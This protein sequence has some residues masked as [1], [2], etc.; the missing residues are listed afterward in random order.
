[1]FFKK[2]F[3]LLSLLLM[4]Y[5]A[6]GRKVQTLVDKRYGPGSYHEGVEAKG[7]EPGLYFTV[8]RLAVV[9]PSGKCLFFNSIPYQVHHRLVIDVRVS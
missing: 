8:C 3:L 4:V 5:D 9:R 1:M 7:L 2:I 6:L